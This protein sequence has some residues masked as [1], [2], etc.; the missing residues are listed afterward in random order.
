M[1]SKRQ[2]HRSFIIL[3]AHD[4]GYSLRDGREP[5]GYGKLEIRNRSGRIQLYIQDMRPADPKRAIYDVVLV[6]GS[7]DVEPVKLTSIQL[8]DNGRGE[9]EISFD[10][11]DVKETGNRIG[12]YHA[13]AVVERTLDRNDLLGCP[14]IGYS[15]KRVDLDW[16]G[17][18]R[19]QLTQMY[20]TLQDGGLFAISGPERENSDLET[21]MNAQPDEIQ[22]DSINPELLNFV[23][24]DISYIYEGEEKEEELEFS[25]SE[26]SGEAEEGEWEHDHQEPDERSDPYCS[27]QPEAAPYWSQAE[28][29]YNRLFDRHKKVTPFDDVI[30]EVDWI[31]LESRHETVYP[32]Y[33]SD[34]PAYLYGRDGWRLDHYLVGLVR[35]KGKVEYVVYGIPGIYSALPPMSM[36]G[37]SRWLPVKNGYGAGY[38][39]L[40]IDAAT[41]NIAYPY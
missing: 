23:P 12:D 28:E 26:A 41:G 35:S 40:Y 24:P 11:N 5:A 2:F 9:Y 15:D 4:S 30:G 21:N 25:L 36:H 37:F 10:P 31:R 6:S 13:L 38:W 14:L 19:R 8:P 33:W 1:L 3:K 39:L 16:S 18:V 27:M 29:Y 17:R 7:S 32:Q 20:R 34:Y 22:E